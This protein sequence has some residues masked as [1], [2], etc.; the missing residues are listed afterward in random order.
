MLSHIYQTMRKYHFILF[1][2]ITLLLPDV[3]LRGFLHLD[4]FKEG[5]VPYVAT[6]FSL[7]WICFFIALCVFILPKRAGKPIF[8]IISVFFIVF[9]FSEYVYYRIFDQFYWMKSV[10]LAGEGADYLDHAVRQIDFWLLFYTA[11][12]VLLLVFSV[13]HWKSPN[14]SIKKKVLAICIPVLGLSILHISLHPALHGDSLNQWDSWRKP[15]AVYQNF[16]DINKSIEISG[17]YQFTY[18]SAYNAIFPKKVLNEEKLARVEE[19]FANKEKPAENRYTELFKGKNVIAVMMESMDSW[20]IDKE[21]TPTIYNMM[22]YGIEFTNYNPP[23]FGA[24]F[25]FGS[26]FAFNTG[27]FT[28]VSAVTASKF[29]ANYFPYSLARLF[30]EAGYKTNSF[31]FNDAEFYNR[32]I[33][34]KC[35]GYEKYHSFD[36]FGITGVEAELDSNMLKSDALYQAMTKETPFFSF[37]ITYSAHLPYKGDSPKLA[38]AKT[39]RSDLLDETMHEEKNNVQILAADTDEF[40]RQ[41]LEKL[42]A[43]G[44]L[45]DTVIIAYTDHFAYGVSDTEALNEWRGDSLSY[46][47]PAF[48]YATGIKPIKIAKPMMTIDWAPT[49][50]NLFG[51]NQEARYIGHDI[52]DPNHNGFVF[53]ENWG[54]MDENMYYTLSDDT[55]G[56]EDL[57]YIEKQNQRVK[58]SIETNDAVIL[59]D[60]YKKREDMQ[61]EA[62]KSQKP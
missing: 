13:K 6:G 49:I 38:L 33:M 28:P 14:L 3:C 4:V 50:V 55:A 52:F 36:E 18:L 5:Y 26:E 16:T 7:L 29:S 27:F 20:M 1:C 31:H 43:D 19:Y 9:S 25:T 34:H 17:I 45:E 62:A 46:N 23:F 58:E 51:L 41:L 37:I 53:Y 35:F 11:C 24:G 57:V 30:K 48:I 2:V 56:S 12:S 54:W 15:R 60:Y 40:F 59:G 39:Y 42:E 22:K 32:G 10:V 47:V 8:I 21:T 44:L 61:K